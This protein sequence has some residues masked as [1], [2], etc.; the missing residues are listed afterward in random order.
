MIRQLLL[1]ILRGKGAKNFDFDQ[2]EMSFLDHLEELRWH[3]VKAAVGLVVAM[4]LCGFFVEFIVQK[5]LLSPLLAVG[6]KAQV[7]APYGIVMLYIQAVLVC[8]LV[9]SMP[10]TL[11]WLWKFIAPG[12]MP[13]ERR[14]VSGIVG[15]TSFFFFSGCA[16]GYFVLVPTALT[17]FAGF[18]TANIALNIAVDR[19][20]SF[21]LALVLGSGLV[22]ELPMLT[23]FLAKLGIVS[24]DFMR[25]YRRHAYVVILL[26]AAVV[27]P[28]PDMVTQLLMAAPMF[29]LYELSIFIAKFVYKKKE[30]KEKAEAAGT[31]EDTAKS[32]EEL[33]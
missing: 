11:Y 15:S 32:D 25:K 13:T 10:N 19:Y 33:W 28:T 17:F 5:V 24:A 6:L 16:F 3:I 20:I 14:Y 23:Y 7:L 2:R 27:T 8:G 29:V 31:H 30:E 12:L 9:L 21:L 22:F 26:I 1:R 4:V 18:G